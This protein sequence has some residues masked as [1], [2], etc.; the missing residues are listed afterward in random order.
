LALALVISFSFY[1]LHHC[2]LV[3]TSYTL[4]F[5]LSSQLMPD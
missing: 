2:S 1:L 3:M 4:Y 5:T